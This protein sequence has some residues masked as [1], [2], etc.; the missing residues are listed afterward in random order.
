MMEAHEGNAERWPRALMLALAFFFALAGALVAAEDGSP[1]TSVPGPGAVPSLPPMAVSEIDL[2]FLPTLSDGNIGPADTPTKVA[3]VLQIVFLL[4]FISLA[5]GMLMLGTCFLRILIVFSF[6]RR[7]LGT[8]TMPPDQMLV[9]LALVL[10]V[11]VM[12]PTWTRA[13]ERGMQPYLN[14]SLDPATG[15]PL[16]QREMFTRMLEP[17][18]EFMAD[19]LA[20]NNGL[21]E[22]EFFMGVSGHQRRNSDGDLVWIGENGREVKQFTE[23]VLADFPTVALVPAFISSELKRAF[24]MGFLLYLPFL[25][26]DMVIASVLMSMGMMMLPPV[27]ISLPFKI[28]MFILIDGWQLLMEATVM[29]F[30]QSVLMFSPATP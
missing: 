5:P 21:D 30:P 26:M 2:S 16:T 19:C 13:W 10:T 6:F 20:A 11:F 15:E 22:M 4:T 17:H 14:E 18:R 24:W 28:I 1:R 9:G 12:Y 3:S 8:Q 25:I 23:L 7:A 27:M 29:S